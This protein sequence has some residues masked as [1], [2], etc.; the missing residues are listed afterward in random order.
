M[1]E[2]FQSL[3]MEVSIMATLCVINYLQQSGIDGNREKA[4][5]G[6]PNYEM[7]L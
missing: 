2:T 5:E 1:N 4:W 7:M 3:S 6:I